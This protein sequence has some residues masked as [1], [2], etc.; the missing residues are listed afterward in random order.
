MSGAAMSDG[1][2]LMQDD[3]SGRTEIVDP[4]EYAE[5]SVKLSEEAIEEIKSLEESSLMA[6]QRLGM[7]LVG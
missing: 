5:F 7:F 2:K 4:N 1:L 3:Q 6:E